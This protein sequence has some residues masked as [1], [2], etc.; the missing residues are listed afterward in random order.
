MI[1]FVLVFVL[2]TITPAPVIHTGAAQHRTIDRVTAI[3]VKR[4]ELPRTAWNYAL[5]VS[6]PFGTL[7]TRWRVCSKQNGRCYIGLQVD[8]SKQSDLAYQRRTQ[9]GIELPPAWYPKLGCRTSEP[10]RACRVT[11]Q[12]VK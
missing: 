4:A 6:S 7:G 9:A 10:P 12:R 5:R 2:H 8:V 1:V 11:L 3:R